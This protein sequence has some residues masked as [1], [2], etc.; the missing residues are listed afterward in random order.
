MR[1]SDVFPS[2]SPS[3]P[4]PKPSCNPQHASRVETA[5]MPQYVCRL[6]CMVLALHRSAAVWATS[7]TAGHDLGHV[8]QQGLLSMPCC[9][10]RMVVTAMVLWCLSSSRTATC[11]QCRRLVPLRSRCSLLFLS[12]SHTGVRCSRWWAL[13]RSWATG[14]WRRLVGWGFVVGGD[15]ANACVHCCHRAPAAEPYGCHGCCRHRTPFVFAAGLCMAHC[16]ACP[17][18]GFTP[19]MHTTCP[20]SLMLRCCCCDAAAFPCPSTGPLYAVE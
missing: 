7:S 11:R 14:R 9:V 13:W 17:W 15:G 16:A 2:L 5:T 18:A 8:R 1:A 6:L 4:T 12:T 10:C 20:T 19:M 3:P